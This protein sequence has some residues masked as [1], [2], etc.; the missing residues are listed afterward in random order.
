MNLLA[1][2]ILNGLR[3]V[4]VAYTFNE[5][6]FSSAVVEGASMQPTL[7]SKDVLILNRWITRFG[8]INK[9]DIV[10]MR[11]LEEPLKSKCKRVVALEGERV[12]K[13]FFSTQIV[14][15]GHVWVEGDNRNNSSDSRDFGPVPVGMITGKVAFRIFP[16]ERIGFVD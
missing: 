14:P 13:G 12:K 11:A 2:K 4:C 3:I 7:L 16:F 9:E 8:Y 6:A 10:V 5:F 1:R 15:R